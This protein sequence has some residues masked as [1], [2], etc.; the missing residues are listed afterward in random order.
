MRQKE[1]YSPDN[2]QHTAT[3]QLQ[4]QPLRYPRKCNMNPEGI[5]RSP[6]TQMNTSS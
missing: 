4:Q 2:S 3:D 6:A 1:A 5:K